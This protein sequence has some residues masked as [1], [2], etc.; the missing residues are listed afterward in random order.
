MKMSK[1]IIQLLKFGIIGFSNT[2]ITAAIIWLL[3]KILG[4]DDYISNFVGYIVGLLNSYYWNYKWTFKS[5]LSHQNTLL[6]FII[7][8]VICYLLQL[9]NLYLLRNYT[10]I[11]QYMCQILSIGVYTGTNFLMNKYYTFKI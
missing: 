10:Q 2:L 11:D 6:K 5:N 4:I 9:G 7:T 8:F 1:S 3:L